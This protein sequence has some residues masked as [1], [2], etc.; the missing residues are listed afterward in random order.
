MVTDVTVGFVDVGTEEG[1]EPVSDGGE[2]LVA[3]KAADIGF[4]NIG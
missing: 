4:E 2:A 1:A 3:V